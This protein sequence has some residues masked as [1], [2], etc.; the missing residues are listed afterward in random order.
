MCF[1][2]HVLL[3]NKEEGLCSSLARANIAEEVLVQTENATGM[4]RPFGLL[5]IKE[6]GNW[7]LQIRL[8]DDEEQ[9]QFSLCYAKRLGVK[10][11]D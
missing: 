2:V 5:K 1:N 8:W 9:Y 10:N 6:M 7:N 11:S 4:K 3:R